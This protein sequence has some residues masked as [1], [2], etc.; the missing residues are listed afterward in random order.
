MD[1]KRI[2]KRLQAGLDIIEVDMDNAY[3]TLLN[4]MRS[5]LM[6]LEVGVVDYPILEDIYKE[7]FD[8]E[9]VAKISNGSCYRI[10]KDGFS[11]EV[12]AMI[13][14][15]DLTLKLIVN[16]KYSD[17]TSVITDYNEN[18]EKVLNEIDRM[19]EL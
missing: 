14:D 12:R 16:G 9:I 19:L 5:D 18:K 7:G 11:G 10:V 2:F 6:A 13:N 1:R 8:F 4:S 3:K 15:K 17:E